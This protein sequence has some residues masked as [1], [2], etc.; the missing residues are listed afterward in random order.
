MRRT[1]A[2][3]AVACFVATAAALGQ[4]PG[5][6]V[7]T[8]TFRA[9]TRLIEV[10]VLVHDRNGRPVAGLTRDDFTLLEDGKTHPIDFFSVETSAGGDAGPAG[11]AERAAPPAGAAGEFSNRPQRGLSGGVTAI[12]FDRVNTTLA[13]QNQ[14]RSQIAKF[15]QQIRPEDRVAL[16]SLDTSTVRILH[17]FTSSSAS[18]LRALSWPLGADRPPEDP[19][20]AAWISRTTDTMSQQLTQDRVGVTMD[21][22][23]AI[24]AHLAGTR[25]RK[26]LIWVSS[27]VPFRVRDETMAIPVARAARA[28]DDANIAIYPVDARGLVTTGVAPAETMPELSAMKGQVTSKP[29]L[30]ERGV[31]QTVPNFET[32]KALAE[33]TGGRAFINSNAIATAIRSAIDDSRLTYVLGYYPSRDKLDGSFRRITIKVNRP[34][35]DVRHRSGY[36]AFPAFAKTSAQPND[37]LL[38]EARSPL[39][40]AG[41]GVTVHASPAATSAGNSHEVALA[42]HVDPDALSIWKD[43]D[44]WSVSLALAFTQSAPDGHFVKTTLGNVDVQVPAARYEQITTKGFSFERNV[45]LAETADELHVVLRD[46]GSGAMGSVIIPL[47]DLKSTSRH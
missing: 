30:P 19:D 15:L 31:A 42:I 24:A 36:R 8:P 43:G 34:G 33:Y 16:Y 11:L 13:D 28:I 32:M 29:V 5:G 40:A 41:L 7:Q 21:A 45:A 3:I 47:S 22:L 14:A 35:V 38:A 10:S 6:P 27:G 12:L 46:A 17:D 37:D 2:V 20:V 26:S 4:A 39:A 25:G 9:D 23:I 18:L 1:L 44:G